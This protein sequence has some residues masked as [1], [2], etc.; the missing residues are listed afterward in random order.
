[1]GMGVDKA[2]A[3]GQSLCIQ[4]FPGLERGSLPGT[5]LSDPSLGYAHASLIGR[6]PR[7]IYN[8]SI[9]N[10]YIHHHGFLPPSTV[11]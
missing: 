9:L 5:H 8:T 7:S 4:R 10:A 6:P 3:K 11:K 1:M 2:G